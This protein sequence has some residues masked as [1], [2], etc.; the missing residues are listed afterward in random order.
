MNLKTRST[1]AE[2]M[3]DLEIEGEVIDKTLRELDRINQ[4]LGGN[5]ISL[6]AFT[7]ILKTTEVHSVVDL[8]CGSADI[9]KRMARI[10]QRNQQKIDFKGIDANRN[11]VTY[12]NQHVQDWPNI[13]VEQQN[14]FSKKFQQEQ[15]DVIH[16]C[17]FLHHFT[18]DELVG[19]FQSFRRQARIAIVVNDLHRHFLAY[20]SIKWLTAWFSRSYMVKNDAAVSV[21]RGFKKKELKSILKQAGI[22]NY[23][24]MWKWAFRWQLVIRLT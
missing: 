18:E 2:I 10:A 12:A 3:D 1:E 11:I 22:T 9:L 13:S 16:C 21:A 24:L 8:G 5:A 17:L 14:I 7:K 15:Y 19:L 4:L 6:S 23:Q 20:H